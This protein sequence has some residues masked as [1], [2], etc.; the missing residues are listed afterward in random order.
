MVTK[1]VLI[2]A[3]SIKKSARCVAGREFLEDA[4]DT[5]LGQWIRPVSGLDEG[6]LKTEHFRLRSG[7][8][9][10]VL[11]IVDMD[12][13]SH[14][15]DPGQPENWLLADKAPWT[16]VRSLLA[17]S[18]ASLQE[19]PPNL[20]MESNSRSNRIAVDAQSRRNPQS[21]I[22]MIRPSNL[23]IEL[24]RERNPWRD[25]VQ[26]KTQAAFR[27]RGQD[28]SLSLTD[29]VFSQQHCSNHPK[30]EEG[31]QTIVPPCRD[32]CLLCVSLTPPF[33]GYHYKL[34]ATVLD[35]P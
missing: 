3:N 5:R 18:V 22:V 29:P 13:V 17:T 33:N 23:K 1:R 8:S 7:E 15:N 9:A 30:E 19:D 2:L 4:S 6:E 31:V 16:K 26:R 24:W 27:Y 28:Y 11:D 12:L 21:S 35:L 32:N 20:W 14:K 25:Y 34:V 10:R